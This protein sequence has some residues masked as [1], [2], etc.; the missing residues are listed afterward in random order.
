MLSFYVHV[1]DNQDI[2]MNSRNKSK[3]IKN[4][5]FFRKWIY[6][7]KQY[8][9]L[10]IKTYVSFVYKQN[11]YNNINIQANSYEKHTMSY[12]DG[13]GRRQGETKVLILMSFLPIHAPSTLGTCIPLFFLTL[14]F[15]L[16]QNRNRESLSY[17]HSS[18]VKA[19]K[20]KKRRYRDT[21]FTSQIQNGLQGF[22]ISLN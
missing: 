4:D 7:S 19:F 5:I 17:S 21:H 16:E 9:I 3:E 15:H 10:F 14:H 20:S 13:G 1:C 6:S 18:K 8:M 11:T 2:K 22:F 12:N